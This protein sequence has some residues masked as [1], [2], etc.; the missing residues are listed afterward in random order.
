[1]EEEGLRL[2]IRWREEREEQRLG[3]SAEGIVDHIASDRIRKTKRPDSLHTVEPF[4]VVALISCDSRAVAP[5]HNDRGKTTGCF[6]RS[7]T[8]DSLASPSVPVT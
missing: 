3:S 7:H 2:V 1:M 6:G 4:V 5:S 8:A